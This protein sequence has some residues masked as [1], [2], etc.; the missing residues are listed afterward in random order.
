M[1]HPEPNTTSKQ[2]CTTHEPAYVDGPH[3]LGAVDLVPTDG[4]EVYVHVV[5][6][7]RDLPHCLR[8]VSVKEGPG[9]AAHAPYFLD[10]LDHAWR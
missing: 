2:E 9:G 10:R 5:D 6:V 1:R 8:G 7:E 4:H 3:A